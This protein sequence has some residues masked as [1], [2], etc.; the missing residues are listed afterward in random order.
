[1]ET[2]KDFGTDVAALKLES[3]DWLAEIV[4]VPTSTIVTTS[5]T[6]VQTEVVEEAYVIGND[7]EVDAGVKS[8]GTAPYDFA[9]RFEN[10]IVCSAFEITRSVES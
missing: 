9:G 10:V 1:M 5:P 2:V 4:Q 3:P 8:K 7:A 6:M